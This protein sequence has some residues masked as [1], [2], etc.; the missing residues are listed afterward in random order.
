MPTP[1]S[2][3]LEALA[4][5]AQSKRARLARAAKRKSILGRSLT[6]SA[7]VL[8]L[9]SA[10]SIT[11]IITEITSSMTVKVL[12]ACLGFLSGMIS[13]VMTSFFDEKETNRLFEGATRF[14]S[15]RDQVELVRLQPNL[16]EKQAF[17]ALKKL[18]TD[19]EKYS[20]E[21]DRF[22]LRPSAMWRH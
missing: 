19:Y 10:G 17:E 9:L 2:A 18:R 22:I 3:E 8:A 16:T 21:Y 6:L 11:A 1:F 5:R 14:L 20:A 12:S 13:L 15:L 4:K 7:G